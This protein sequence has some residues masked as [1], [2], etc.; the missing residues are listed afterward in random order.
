MQLQLIPD[1]TKRWNQELAAIPTARG[2]TMYHEPVTS[3]LTFITFVDEYGRGVFI[4]GQT[5]YLQ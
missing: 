5:A 3:N 2:R 1:R 4:A